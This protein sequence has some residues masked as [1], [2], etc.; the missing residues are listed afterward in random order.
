M[1]HGDW[2]VREDVVVR[3]GR[4]R[5]A[6]RIAGI[7]LADLFRTA[8]AHGG[9]RTTVGAFAAPEPAVRAALSWLV[10]EGFLVADGSRPAAGSAGG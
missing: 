9:I 6:H 7:A 4:H 1:L 8:S 10:A 2:I 3:P 5:P